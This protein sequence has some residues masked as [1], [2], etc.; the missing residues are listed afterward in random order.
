MAFSIAALS[1]DTCFF[2]GG[3]GL[4][5]GITVPV[6][7]QR[8]P[9]KAEEEVRAVKRYSHKEAT[10]RGNHGAERVREWEWTTRS[11][12]FF[13]GTTISPLAGARG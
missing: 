6:L 5:F 12:S 7:L 10:R 3:R 11:T 13:G 4:G 1:T 2:G 9:Q 8:K